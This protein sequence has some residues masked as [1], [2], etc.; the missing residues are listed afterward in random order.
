MGAQERCSGGGASI[1][2][3]KAE[4]R[5]HCV[6]TAPAAYPSYSGPGEMLARV[7]EEAAPIVWV[8]LNAFQLESLKA[9]ALRHGKQLRLTPAQAASVENLDAQHVAVGPAP[10]AQLA[11]ASWRR[12]CH[13][14]R[15]S[16]TTGGR[17]SPPA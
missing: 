17:A 5:E 2:A 4:C 13:I 8:R 7:F 12:A 15:A 10:A 14:T 16:A 11:D 9:V 1:E 6:E 3:L